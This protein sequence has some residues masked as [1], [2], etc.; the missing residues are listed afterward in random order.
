MAGN[1]VDLNIAFHFYYLTSGPVPSGLI[2]CV[3]S[4]ELLILNDPKSCM[5]G[6]VASSLAMKLLSLERN[7]KFPEDLK[8][9]FT[10]KFKF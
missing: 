2:I 3:V 8:T 10:K 9:V 5:V 4:G 7:R 1:S 6:L